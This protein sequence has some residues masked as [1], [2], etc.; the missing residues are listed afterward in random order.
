MTDTDTDIAS[1]S[2]GTKTLILHIRVPGIYVDDLP[3]LAAEWDCE[4]VDMLIEEQIRADV[5]LTIVTLPGEKCM[6]DDFEVHAYTATIVGADVVDNT[7][8]G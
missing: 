5:G 6:N 1:T 8:P 7:V 4:I 3:G 2:S